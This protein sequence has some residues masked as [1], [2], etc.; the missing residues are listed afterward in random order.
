MSDTGLLDF[1]GIS[2][3]GIACRKT[4]Y[5]TEQFALEHIGII[6]K[7]TTRGSSPKRAYLCKKCNNWHITKQESLEE[8]RQE[9]VEIKELLRS[10]EEELFKVR[11]ALKNT[12][13]GKNSSSG[14]NEFQ[15]KVRVLEK[16]LI[17]VKAKS[18]KNGN[19]YNEISLKLNTVK[20]I[21][22]K[23]VKNKYSL[24]EVIKRLQEKL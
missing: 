1:S 10:R 20:N 24:E 3:V 9:L 14:T 13:N 12:E 22:N 18:S 7:K 15:I 11:I 16:E 2:T 19:K 4:S 17:Q 5:S 6:A 23:A 8:L 21:V